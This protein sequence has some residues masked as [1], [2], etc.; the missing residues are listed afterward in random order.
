ME[1][2]SGN[3]TRVLGLAALLS[4]PRLAE[5]VPV[6]VDPAAQLEQQRMQALEAGRNEGHAAGMAR[7]DAEIADI[8]RQ[9]RL[10]IEQTQAAENERLAMANRSAAELLQAIPQAMAEADGSVD[11]M[12]C[13]IAY[14]ALVRYLGVAG[15]DGTLLERI[16]REALDEYRLRPVIVRVPVADAAALQALSDGAAITVEGDA[17]LRPGQCRLQTW[18][19]DYDTGLEVRLDA[20]KQAFLRSLDAA[21]APA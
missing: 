15:V 2:M 18:K 5:P 16:C 7:A 4:Q 17:H 12:V 20:I 8:A 10:G 11:S 1:R 21:E 9:T 13:E 6:A 19:G 14:A 3:D